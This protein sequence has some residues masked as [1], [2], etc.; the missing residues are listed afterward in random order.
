MIK[1]TFGK[2]GGVLATLLIILEIFAILFIVV[3]KMSGNTPTLFGH[4]MYIIVSPSMEPEINVG[5]V[6]ISEK[7]DGGELEV[8]QVVTYYGTRGDVAGKMI[9]HKIV[10]IDGDKIITQGVANTN[11]D[12]AIRR[13]EVRSVMKRNTVVLSAVYS[14][15]STTA[16]FICLVILPLVAMIVSEIVGLVLEVKKEGEGQNDEESDK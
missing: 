12:P 3:G 9:T 11:P 5:D 10:E 14:V 6:I 4:Q 13:D 8:G 16:G 15:I 7:Y 2:I 1:K